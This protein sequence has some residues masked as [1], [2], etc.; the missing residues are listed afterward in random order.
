MVVLPNEFHKIPLEIEYQS[1]KYML[2]CIKCKW[3]FCRGDL[4]LKNFGIDF[5]AGLIVV[6][7]AT[8]SVLVD[9][10]VQLR[11]YLG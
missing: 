6:A 10:L 11:Q 7:V 8:H 5:A 4:P 9:G 2:I 3:C 1:N